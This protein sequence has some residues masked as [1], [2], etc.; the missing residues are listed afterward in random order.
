MS[1]PF[2]NLPASLTPFVGRIP[3]VATLSHILRAGDVRMLTVTGPGGIGKTRLALRVVADMDTTFADGVWFVPLAPLTDPEL[4]LPTIAR[5]LGLTEEQPR[6]VTEMLTA[7][8]HDKHL[9]LVLDNCEHLL[10]A[11]ADLADLLSHAPDLTILATSRTPLK[12]YGEYEYLVPPLTLPDPTRLTDLPHVR[13]ADAVTLFVQR[14]QAIA[15]DFALTTAN[16]PIIAQICLRL[17]GLP[18]ALELAAGRTKLFSPDALL[19][20]MVNR[21]ALLRDGA[22]SLP[23]RHQTLRNTLDWSYALLTEAEQILLLRVSVFVGGFTLDAVEAVC[24]NTNQGDGETA[25]TLAGLVDKSLVH[26]VSGDARRFSLLEMVREY[27]R[28]KYSL[29]D[30]AHTTPQRHAAYYLALAEEA[31]PIVNNA[32]P[33]VGQWLDRLEDESPNFRAAFAWYGAHG[34]TDAGVRLSAALV[35]FWLTR[36]YVSEG[37]RW[38]E[39]TLEHGTNLSDDVRA[40]ATNRLGLLARYQGD[41]ARARDLHTQALHLWQELGDTARIPFA[42]AALGLT[43]FDQGDDDAARTYTLKVVAAGRTHGNRLMLARALGVLGNIALRAEDDAAATGYYE[44]GLSTQS[45]NR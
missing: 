19:A 4:V 42:L 36:G 12:I 14:A 43:A 21:L 35:W 13:Q 5:N 2:P 41:Y 18:L 27:T 25:D 37:R 23:L 30:D 26:R 22:A 45:D 1:T 16:A 32:A 44:G 31:D 24:G 15:P 9:L 10:P 8:L 28:E 20:R 38:L 6:P 34:D 40:I 39:T 3:E 7:F 17:D 29:R 11:M 33:G